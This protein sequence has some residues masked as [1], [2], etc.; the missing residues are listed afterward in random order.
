MKYPKTLQTL[1]SVID[2]K[3]CS[4]CHKVREIR[5]FSSRRATKCNLCKRTEEN[6]KWIERMRKAKEKQAVV[7]KK[8]KRPSVAE[9]KKKVQKMVNKK[10]RERDAKEPCISCQ[11]GAIEHAGHYIAQGSTGALRFDPDNIHGQCSQCNVWKHGNLIEYRIN[12]VKKIG[13]ERVERLERHR[14]DV[15]KWTREDLEEIEKALK[16]FA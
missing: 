3:E 14:H 4:V 8:A 13:L 9:L 2:R 5:F 11:K 10:V 1:K 16:R 6:N 12:L 15:E 7:V